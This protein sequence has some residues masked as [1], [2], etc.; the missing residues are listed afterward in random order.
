MLAQK[1]REGCPLRGRINGGRGGVA[2]VKYSE[3][4]CRERRGV[5]MGVRGIEGVRGRESTIL[6]QFPPGLMLSISVS[7]KRS[8][9]IWVSVVELSLLYSG[10][11]RASFTVSEEVKD[12]LAKGSVSSASLRNAKKRGTLKARG[13]LESFVVVLVGEGIRVFPQTAQ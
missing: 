1:N 4:K 7:S 2:T 5:G 11:F 9:A 6:C 3:V 8:F 13:R 12:K 10:I